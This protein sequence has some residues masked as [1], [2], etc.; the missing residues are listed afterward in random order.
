MHGREKYTCK[1]CWGTQRMRRPQKAAV[2]SSSSDQ[3][4][5][6]DGDDDNDKG[7]GEEERNY[8]AAPLRRHPAKAAPPMQA[9]ML[10]GEVQLDTVDLHSEDELGRGIAHMDQ[11][12]GDGSRLAPAVA[13]YA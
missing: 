5:A 6:D 12:G 2:K 4:T 9:G 3:D 10:D 13:Q 1:E 11:V 8:G 7:D